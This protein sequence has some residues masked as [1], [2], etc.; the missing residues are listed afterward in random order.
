MNESSD[1]TKAP[2]SGTS[3]PYF[4]IFVLTLATFMSV[5]DS[6]IANVALPQIAS[7]LSSTPTEGFWVLTSYIIATAAIIP[8]SGWL[9]TYFGR[10]RYYMMSVLGFTVTSVLC[11]L[12]TNLETLIFFRILQGLCAGGIAPSEQAIIADIIPQERLG[13]A[14]AIYGAGISVAPVLGPTVGGFITDTLSWHWIFFINL[15][16]GIVSLILTAVFVKESK[17]AETE[18]ERRANRK[19]VD[20][21]G[22]F[23]FVSGVAVLQYVL[24]EG[25]ERDWLESDFILVM[26]VYAIAA[27]AAGIYWSLTRK[28]PAVDLSILSDRGFAGATIVIMAVGFAVSG[29]GFLIP[30][31]TQTLLDYTAMD[32]GLTGL[33]G[34]IC[35]LG[36]I[37]AVGYF[38]D[39][40][41]IRVIIFIG[42]AISALAVWN[43]WGINLNTGFNDLVIARVYFAIGIGFLATTVNTVAYYGISPDKNNSASAMLNLGRNMGASFGIALTS[44]IIAT[45]SQV[46]VNA[47]ASNASSHNSN[48]TQAVDMLAQ[49]LQTHGLNAVQAV[50][51]AQGYLWREVLR[52]SLMNSIL[53]AIGVYLIIHICVIPLVFLLRSKKPKGGQH[54]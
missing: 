3:H 40:T 18:A 27:L 48:F 21:T 7:D 50:G 26:F 28:D 22:I 36:V 37:Q 2:Q 52:Q 35:Q 16:I 1:S 13:R 47:V 45:R 42:L 6:S 43:L 25:P 39:K 10:K 33:A 23:L 24:V 51:A 41:D 9:A 17:T 12:A 34:T 31:F 44:T 38:S 54:A 30:Y 19:K 29:V 14:F 15:P 32:A 53:D 20:W 11:G 5:L 8:I 46:H 49:T 4:S